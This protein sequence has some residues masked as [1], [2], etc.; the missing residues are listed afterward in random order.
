VCLSGGGPALNLT[1][2]PNV[3]ATDRVRCESAGSFWIAAVG[4]SGF[5]RKRSGGELAPVRIT[6]AKRQA[7]PPLL[8]LRTEGTGCCYQVGG[9]LRKILSFHSAPVD[10]KVLK[11]K[12]RTEIGLFSFAHSVTAA[13][14]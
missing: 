5:L 2:N 1:L 6:P 3:A 10:P 12:P 7:I 14:T 13:M 8:A 4:R 9:S 11:R